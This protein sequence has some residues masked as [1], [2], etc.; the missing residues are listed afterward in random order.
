MNIF[1]KGFIG[2][3]VT[4][5]DITHIYFTM[6]FADKTVC[7]NEEQ[8]HDLI[9]KY[10]WAVVEDA[11]THNQR[12]VNVSSEEKKL[13]SLRIESL[14][15]WKALDVYN[16]LNKIL[17]CSTTHQRLLIADN[18]AFEFHQGIRDFFITQHP[19]LY[20]ENEHASLILTKP[21]YN[22][23]NVWGVPDEN[24]EYF[25]ANTKSG[26]IRVPE[27]EQQQ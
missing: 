13:P 9:S 2:K 11:K 20:K 10:Y 23:I 1:T 24:R 8:A 12:Q 17:F 21:G 7:A 19:L 6:L 22:G 27:P 14:K 26:L 3:Y 4:T 25:S 16:G 18:G 5:R 15:N